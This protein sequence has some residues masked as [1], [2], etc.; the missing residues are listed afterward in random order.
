MA[1][2]KKVTTTTDNPEKR[3]AV[4]MGRRTWES[5]PKKF[6]PLAGRLNVVLTRS[7]QDHPDISAI[8]GVEVCNSLPN[9]L[10]FLSKEDKGDVENVFVMGGGQIYDEAFQSKHLEKVLLTKVETDF[11]CDTFIKFDSS[12]FD[13]KDVSETKEDDG[14]SYKFVT[15]EPK[16]SIGIPINMRKEPNHEEWQYLDMIRECIEKGVARGDRTGTGTLSLFGRTMRYSLR[17]EVFPLLTTKRVFWRGLAEELLWFVKGCTNANELAEKKIHIWDG[18]GSREF[19]DK[20]GLT[21]RAVGDLGPVYGFQ[22]RHFGA[23]YKDMN[24]DYSGEGIDQ[25]NYCI[26]LIKNNPTSRRILLTAWNP[27]D[28]SKM[29]LPPCHMFCQFFV[30]NGELSCQMYQRS[31]DMGLGVPFNIASY[32]LLTRMM[33]QVCGLKAGE[34]VHVI[35]DCHVYSNHV[36]PLK[37]QLEREPKDFPLLKIN[38]NVTDIDKFNFSDFEI[39]GYKP[40][41]RIAMKMAV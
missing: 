12:R 33:A 13:E 34:F 24:A 32:S 29:A 8:E 28:L 18:N 14:V 17:N 37:E 22:W 15:L 31:A 10:E 21:E 40:H 2:F 26:D 35:G 27:A 7:P 39:I 3:N 41:K 23:E 11:K 9:A 5:I 30:A 6:R 20:K 36:E 25:L 38:P 19:L 16:E 1:F 4:V